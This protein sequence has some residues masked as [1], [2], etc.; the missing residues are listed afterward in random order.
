MNNNS[1]NILIFGSTFLLHLKQNPLQHLSHLSDL[2]NHLL[3]ELHD[4][5]FSV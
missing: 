2:R 1:D 3:S 5:H 4:K